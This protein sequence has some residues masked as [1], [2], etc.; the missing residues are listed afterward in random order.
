VEYVVKIPAC[1]KPGEPPT[2]QPAKFEMVINLKAAK[3]LGVEIAPILLARA[4]ELS[5]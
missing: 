5:A 2:Q 4:D 3:A 1:E